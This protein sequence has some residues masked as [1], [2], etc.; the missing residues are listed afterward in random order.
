V[1][2]SR[3]NGIRLVCIS[4]IAVGASCLVGR[5]QGSAPP[6]TSPHDIVAARN[7]LLTDAVAA[8]DAAR[9]AAVYAADADL[10]QTSPAGTE[11][12]HGR[13]GIQRLWQS[14][15]DQGLSTFELKISDTDLT[16]GVITERGQFVMKSAAGATISH[17]TYENIWQKEDGQWRLRR[18]QVTAEK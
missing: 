2:K 13:D 3:M 4:A 10:A 14:L 18:N 1:T 15:L 17:G 16:N 12:Q 6:G 5:A 9:I 8:K 7:K 11:K